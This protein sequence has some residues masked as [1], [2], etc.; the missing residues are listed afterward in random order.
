VG[1]PGASFE[2]KGGNVLEGRLLQVDT[3]TAKQ[4][5]GALLK[6]N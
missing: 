1:G 5:C 2:R 3:F 6:G 4:N